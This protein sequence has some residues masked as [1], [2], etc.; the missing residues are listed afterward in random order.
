MTK[1]DSF[2]QPIDN[3]AGEYGKFTWPGYVHLQPRESEGKPNLLHIGDDYNGSGGG[4]SDLG[5]PVKT[6]GDGVVEK[7]IRWNGNYGFGNHLFIKHYLSDYLKKLCGSDII[8]SH[9]AHLDAFRCHEGQEVNKGQEIALLGHSGTRWAHLHLDIRRPIGRGYE[10]YPANKSINWLNER[11]FQPFT[12]I[13]QNN[14]PPA[15]TQEGIGDSGRQVEREETQPIIPDD[16]G[17]IQPNDPFNNVL[18]LLPES[19]SDQPVPSANDSGVGNIPVE[20]PDKKVPKKHWYSGLINFI[21]ACLKE[22][23]KVWTQ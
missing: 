12:F 2:A 21:N 19:G 1:T 17:R 20:K 10:D 6:I 23:V 14:S 4:N 13:Q 3:I 9:Y 22:V 11:Y 7:I 15:Q 8:Y 18:E 5:L 16:A